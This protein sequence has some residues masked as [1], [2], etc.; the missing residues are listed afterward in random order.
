[1]LRETRTIFK[2]K[3]KESSL[4]KV[5]EKLESVLF[6]R[7]I[8]FMRMMSTKDIYFQSDTLLASRF[9]NTLLL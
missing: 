5:R 9:I 1:M 4:L 7:T 6:S 3:I 2:I 8:T